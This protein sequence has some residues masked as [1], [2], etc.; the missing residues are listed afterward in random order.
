MGVVSVLDTLASIMASMRVVAWSALVVMRKIQSNRNH[1]SGR[2]MKTLL[3]ERKRPKL[4]KRRSKL[5]QQL[6]RLRQSFKLFFILLNNAITC[7]FF[8]ALLT[9]DLSKFSDL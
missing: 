1:S 4:T 8:L 2:I 9:L 6:T 7:H 3:M 5:K